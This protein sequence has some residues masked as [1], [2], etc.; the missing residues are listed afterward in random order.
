MA[1]RVCV[2]REGRIVAAGTPTELAAGAQPRLRFRLDRPLDGGA[3]DDLGRRL[4]TERPSAAITAEPDAGR[5]VLDGIAP[6]AA[7]IATLAAWCAQ[8]DRLIVELR[9][10]GGTLEE[11]YLD[12]VGETAPPARDAR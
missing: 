3:L 11:A 1:D 6:D 12:L 4:V 7:I 5:Y 2:L 9:S 8:A 10:A